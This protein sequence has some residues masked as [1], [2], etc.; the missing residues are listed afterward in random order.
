LK[1]SQTWVFKHKMATIVH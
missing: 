1:T